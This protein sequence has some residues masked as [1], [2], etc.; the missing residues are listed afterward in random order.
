MA[1]DAQG[2]YYAAARTRSDASLASAAR[3][4]T[5]TSA[6]FNA[7]QAQALEVSLAVTAFA[8]TSPTLD[9]VLQTSIDGGTTW[10]TVKA[11]SQKTGAAT[12]GGVFGPLG[13]QLRWSWTIG[14]TASPSFTFAVTAKERT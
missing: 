4:A 13:S 3:T 11:F 8:G 1:R 6:A 2:N 9:L 14:G 12:D 10:L 7:A 5:G